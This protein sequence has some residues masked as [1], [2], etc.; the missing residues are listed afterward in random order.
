MAKGSPQRE[1][2][3]RGIY[4]RI[5]AS[6]RIVFEISWRDAQG[7]QRRRRVD[8]G[9]QAAR[10]D[11]AGA[12]SAR[13]RGEHVAADPR[14]KFNDAANAW[15]DARA[16]RLRPTTQAVYGSCLKH[17]RERFGHRR[18]TD[19][20]ATEIAAF[21]AAQQHKGLKGWTV[22]GQLAVLSSVY[23]HAGR[24]LGFVGVNPVGM[25]DR[26]ERP[27][28]EDERAKRV[29]S[30]DELRRLITAVDEPYRLVFEFASE[31]GARLGEVL[32]IVWGEVD[33][34]EA[35]VTFTHQLAKRGQRVPLKTKRSQRSIEIPLGLVTKL[36]AAKL[37]SRRSG[38]H[39]FVFTTRAGT[40][41][42]HRNVAGRVLARAVKRAG[43]EAVERDGRTIE[44][45]PTFH[46]L[47]HTHASAMIHKGLDIAVVSARLGHSD[48]G[49][50]MRTYIHEYEKAQRSDHVRNKLAELYEPVEAQPAGEVV[51]LTV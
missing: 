37:A 28:I 12:H 23:K 32:G 42:D 3:E 41:H 46:N 31:T 24:H 9:I 43:L 18:L 13:G 6:G 8:G 7:H 15:W 27:N 38:D 10:R 29:L 1:K 19:I 47:R 2:V 25:L 26:V 51:P 21:V 4:K 36:R 16:V 45:A 5:D 33:L 49:T 34:D 40:P 48:V 35:T 17:L 50:T 11:L 22:K 14:L 20:T 39:D 44:S 30:G